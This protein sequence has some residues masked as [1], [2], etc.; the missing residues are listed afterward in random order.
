MW[1]D[2]LEALPGQ[3]PTLSDCGFYIAGFNWFSDYLLLPVILS[4]L[5]INPN[6]KHRILAKLFAWSLK[7][8]SKPPFTTELVLEASGKVDGENAE[9]S[10]K[11]RHPDAYL[12]TAAP[13]VATLLQFFDRPEGKS[14]LWFQGHYPEP[15]RFLRDLKDMG[16]EVEEH[17]NLAEQPATI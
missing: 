9:M 13:V 12:L 17:F 4:A 16:I 8:F 11:I 2:E 7:Y 6:G 15:V 10:L 3:F 14:G 1:L 5:A